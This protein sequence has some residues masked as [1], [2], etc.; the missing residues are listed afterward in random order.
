MFLSLLGTVHGAV[1]QGVIWSIMTLGVYITFRILDFPD[2]TVD[3]S[4]ATGGAVAA[5]LVANHGVNPFLAMVGALAAG[6]VCGLITGFLNTKMKIP[7]ILAGIL[8]MTALYS[9]NIR[10]MSGNAMVPLNGV[11]T[12]DML[13]RQWI[14]GISANNVQ[15]LI[16]GV[17]AA[18]A[19]VFLYWF[20]GTELGCAIRATG[21]NPYMVRS[22]GVHTD[23]T[24]M[25]ALVISNGLVALSGGIFAQVNGSASVDMGVG[26][27][28]IGLASVIIGEVVLGRHVG[29][30]PRLVCMVVGSIIYRV[31]IAVVLFLGLKATDMKLISAIIVAIALFLPVAKRGIQRMGGH[32]KA[33]RQPALVPDQAIEDSIDNSDKDPDEPNQKE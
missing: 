25:V 10:I 27:I 13:V 26:T 32:H 15:L 20:F 16:G 23:N 9:I 1:A 6:M 22:L 33:T 12:A 28:V 3:G 21:N 8:T 5:V 24:T 17:V 30:I 7:G 29:V 2:L 31:V 18:I 19:V 11:D 14:P 4:F